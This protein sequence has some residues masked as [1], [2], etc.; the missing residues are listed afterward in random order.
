M[1]IDVAALLAPISDEAPCGEAVE[2]DAQFIELETLA[3][4]TPE[5]EVGDTIIPAE[6]PDWREVARIAL[7]LAARSKDLRVAIYVLRAELKLSGLPGLASA[8]ELI[9]GCLEQYWPS[10]HPQL[11]PE[12]DNDP[13]A[14]INVLASLCDPELVLRSVRTAPLSQSRQFGRVSYRDHAIATGILPMPA[15][16][17]GQEEEHIP[18]S[19]TI[20][21]AFADTAQEVLEEI[22][23]AVA[24]SLDHLAGIDVA[25]NAVLGAA[26]GPE[27]DPLRKL[28]R[29]IKAL[30]DHQVA[31][32]G[33][34]AAPAE[35]AADAGMTMGAAP[36]G[37]GAPSGVIRSRSDVALLL[38][39]ICRYYAEHE[40][41]SPVPLLLERAKR[42]AAMN[43]LEILQDLTPDSVQQFGVI[44][45]IKQEEQ[46]Y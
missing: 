26:G 42:L 41:S 19:S 23:A 24:G 30:L 29:E 15:P 35:E 7:E 8:L 18:D 25:L 34:E 46:Q 27:L 4:G 33:G 31:M 17:K 12:D 2:Y 36:A 43:F 16:R 22:Q 38:D 13:S 6:E 1:A 10:V 45:G 20:E 39:K 5:Q 3:R 11:D 9:R 40:P 28:L 21:A 44:A 32:R 37:G 14:R